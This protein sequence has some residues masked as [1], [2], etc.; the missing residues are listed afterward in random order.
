MG[1]I[2]LEHSKKDLSE[3]KQ[4]NELNDTLQN[5]PQ[6]TRVQNPVH[7]LQK[8]PEL[9]QVVNAWAELPEH[10]KQT[11]ETLVGSVTIKNEEI[12]P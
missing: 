11:I 9:Q 10:I 8:H 1:D 3:V 4:N 2:G 12:S 5:T 6:P 7:I